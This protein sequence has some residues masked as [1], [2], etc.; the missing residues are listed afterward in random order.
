VGSALIDTVA[1]A[2]A[3]GTPTVDA[4]QAAVALL[5]DIR[6][7]VDGVSSAS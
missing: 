1:K 6:G 2:R 4:L 5:A 7:G 3:A